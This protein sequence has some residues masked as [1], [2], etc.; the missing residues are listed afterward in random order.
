MT[1]CMYSD[2]VTCSGHGKA[3]SDGSCVC[4]AGFG[5][6]NCGSPCHGGA[7]AFRHVQCSGNGALQ[8]D[9][10]CTCEAGSVPSGPAVVEHAGKYCD[11]YVT[12]S[13]I[14][15][16]EPCQYRGNGKHWAF[17][18]VLLVEICKMNLMFKAVH[19]LTPLSKCLAWCCD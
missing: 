1:A 8:D 17:K 11:D 12:Q 14:S 13:H 15:E 6:A 5:T 16:L 4:D 10:S 18:V 19:D 7:Q 3:Q 9:G 2:A